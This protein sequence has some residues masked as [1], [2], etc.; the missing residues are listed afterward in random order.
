M[1]SKKPSYRGERDHKS[2]LTTIKDIIPQFN[3]ESFS[4]AIEQSL[5]IH[6]NLDVSNVSDEELEELILDMNCQDNNFICR[7]NYESISDSLL[8]LNKIPSL[9]RMGPSCTNI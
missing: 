9:I 8:E 3:L 6:M 2:F 4:S 7:S 1:P 5:R